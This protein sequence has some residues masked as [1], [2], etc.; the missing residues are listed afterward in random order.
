VVDTVGAG[1]TFIA[2]VIAC[3]ADEKPLSVALEAGCR[4]AGN[5]VGQH[6]FKGLIKFFNAN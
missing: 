2:A 3:L 1:D 4:V 6:G 5:K